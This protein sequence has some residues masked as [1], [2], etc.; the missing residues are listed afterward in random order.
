MN[1][2]R[3]KPSFALTL[4]LLSAWA[5]APSAVGLS[6]NLPQP[7]IYFPKDYSTNRAAQIESV[8]R[9]DKF[10]YLGGLVSYWEPEFSTTL[11]YEG[12]RQALSSFLGALNGLSGITVR[13]TFSPDLSK[14]TGSALQAGS[15]WVKYSHTMPDTITVR[16]NLAAESLGGDKFELLLPKPNR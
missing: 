1:S 8:L 9:S 15:W 13:L 3:P 11:V 7:E 16:I 10:K 2:I 12:D 14:E 6:L 4:I 5:V